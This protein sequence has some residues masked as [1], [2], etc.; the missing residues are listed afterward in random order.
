MNLK[1]QEEKELQNKLISKYFLC[2]KVIFEKG[3]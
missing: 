3:N 2:S 1:I